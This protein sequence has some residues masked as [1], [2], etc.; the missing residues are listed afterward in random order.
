[1]A[2]MIDLKLK[3]RKVGIIGV[4]LMG[5]SLALGLR[6]KLPQVSVWGYARSKEF[7]DE[8]KK[9]KI[10]D[11]VERDLKKVVEGADFVVLALPIY[12]ILDYL[13]KISPFLKKG[14]IV[15]D[16][17]SSKELIEKKA[18]GILPKYAS[19]VGC[20]PLCG[21]EKS[22]ARFSQA[23]L[24]ERA[25]C[26]ITSPSRSLTT[27]S[28]QALWEALGSEVV[29][30]SAHLHDKILS[31]VSHFPHLLSF[32]LAYFTP[33]KYLRFSSGSF[34]DLTRIARSSSGVWAEIFLANRKNLCRDLDKFIKV[35][36]N[37]ERMIKRGDRKK[38]VSLI[39]KVNIKLKCKN[40]KLK[41]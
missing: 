27:Q 10:L 14:T 18:P 40:E 35:L 33:Y 11:R 15:F 39:E 22:G 19:F 36:K 32:S 24:Y 26:L 6:E 21:S 16:L 3:I 29:F 38:I 31:A 34:Q 41:N 9:L 37:F 13:K 23:N 4:G 2:V 8:L 28:V 1:M 30:V 17:G 7:Y 25:L 20:H 12:I 5:G